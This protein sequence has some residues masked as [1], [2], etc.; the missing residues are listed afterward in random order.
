MVF[1]NLDGED[2]ATTPETTEAPAPEETAEE[3]APAASSNE[4]VS[5]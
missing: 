5:A 3:A 1:N 4:E 2:T